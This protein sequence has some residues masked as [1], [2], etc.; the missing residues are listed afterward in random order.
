MLARIAN[1]LSLRALTVPVVVVL[2]ACGDA[3]P[4]LSRS[5]IQEMVRAEVAGIPQPAPGLTEAE[6]QEA[7]RTA[8]EAMPQPEPELTLSDVEQIVQAEIGAIP[9]P[10]PGVSPAQVRA[11]IRMAVDAIPEPGLDRDEVEQIV[12]A[13]IA[14]IPE[15]QEG[16]SSD[17][18]ASAIGAAIAAIPAPHVGPTRSDVEE[19][20]QA[21]IGD[22]PEPDV[23]LNRSE[24][25]QVVQT[26]IAAIPPTVSTAQMNDAIRTAI[27]AIPEPD[28]GLSRGDVR[29][30]VDAAVG[31]IPE[32]GVG[33]EEAELIAR[34]TV[35][36]IPP[37]DA[38]ADYTRFFVSNAITRYEV[39]G[40]RATLDYYNRPESVDG[41]WYVFII[42]EDDTVIAHP[43][44]GRL[45]LDLNGWVGIDVNGY[46][47]GPEVLSA[48]EEGRW[49]S[50]VYS[51][52]IRSGIRP[53][54]LSEVE[55]KNVW[56]V[57]HDDLLFA[58]GWYIDVDRL[59]QDTVTTVVD[60]F[61]SSGIEGVI[62]AFTNDPASILG[63]LAASAAS[64]NTSGLV[65][66]E[67]SVLIADPSGSIVFHFN[68]DRIGV[69]LEDLI[70]VDPSGIH[71]D[72]AWLTSE[73]MRIWAVKFDGWVFAAGWHSGQ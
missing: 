56:V 30:I 48:T 35:A 40:L 18:V 49:V 24:V 51:N 25:D 36:T 58:S 2:V 5:E 54:D 7:I 22:I 46:R 21:A 11:A 55:L 31:D 19:I 13:A 68:P 1:L 4:E 45:G 37:R 6:V 71:E 12:Q 65:E 59:T 14:G 38:E 39:D 42:D 43:D 50:Y 73:S 72:G 60:L 63:G 69:R 32:P 29:R 61:R 33:Y 8:M 67:W 9:E 53:D 3:D 57:R 70:G 26:A 15:P 44:P 62:D 17:E 52:P 28:S 41:Q 34:H 66:G 16:L 27:A 23:G 64:Y 47:F 10:E 20:V